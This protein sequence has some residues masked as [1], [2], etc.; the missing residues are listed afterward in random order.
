MKADLKADKRQQ[1]IRIQ[2]ELLQEK[3]KLSTIGQP[4]GGAGTQFFIFLTKFSL[5][6][7]GS[8]I[9]LLLIFLICRKCAVL[10]KY[11]KSK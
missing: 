5:L 9:M 10:F 4:A 3:I 1:Y 2:N 7:A 8:F 6:L 11:F